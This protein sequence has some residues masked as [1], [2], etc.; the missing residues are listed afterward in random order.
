MHRGASYKEVLL[1]QRRPGLHGGRRHPLTA[2][3][4]TTAKVCRQASS[5]RC[6]AK[7]TDD[8]WQMV[9]TKRIRP[10]A[11]S[12]SDSVPRLQVQRLPDNMPWLQEQ[13]L[14]YLRRI[15]GLCFN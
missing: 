6:E 15:K 11:A 10:R 2:D 8:G 14:Q 7:N 5:P 3:G 1:G 13:R 9:K 4:N 12:Q